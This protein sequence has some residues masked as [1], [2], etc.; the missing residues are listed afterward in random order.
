[1]VNPV[2]LQSSAYTEHRPSSGTVYPLPGG[3]ETHH[4]YSLWTPLLLGVHHRVV[5][6]EGQLSSHD[7]L[8]EQYHIVSSF[9]YL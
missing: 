2:C 3:E 4:I 8:T 7:V 5:Q 1:M 9:Y 6:H